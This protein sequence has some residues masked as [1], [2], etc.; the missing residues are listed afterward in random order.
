MKPIDVVIILAS[1]LVVVLVIIKSVKDKKKGKT[2]CGY[3][4]ANCTGCSAKINNDN[5]SKHYAKK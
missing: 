2:C 5:K 3:D 1:V 4:C